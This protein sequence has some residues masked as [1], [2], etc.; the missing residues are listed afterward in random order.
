MKGMP[1][2]KEREPVARRKERSEGVGSQVEVEG[3]Q[4]EVESVIEKW[5]R[6]VRAG[7]MSDGVSGGVVVAGDD[8]QPAVTLPITREEMVRGRKLSVW[9]SLRW[10]AEWAARQVKRL[11]GRVRYKER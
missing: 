9:D 7:G 4:P 8:D 10:L 5:E 1:E 11:A 2:V 3:R 6:Q